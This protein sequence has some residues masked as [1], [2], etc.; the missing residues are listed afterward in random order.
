LVF[1]F[2]LGFFGFWFLG[3]YKLALVFLGFFGY[4]WFFGFSPNQT[5]PQKLKIGIGFFGFFGFFGIATPLVYS[6]RYKAEW[7]YKISTHITLCLL[8]KYL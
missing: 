7:K 6:S 4:F 2:F 1:W 5:L 3:N 8:L